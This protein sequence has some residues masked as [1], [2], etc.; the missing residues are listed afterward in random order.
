MNILAVFAVF[1]GAGLGELLRWRLGVRLNP[2]FPTLPLGTL[3]ANLLGGLLAVA[4]LGRHPGLPPG[5]R[6][7]AITGFLGGL[8]PFSTFAA[9]TV[10]RLAR[11]ELGWGLA[12]AGAHVT[13]SLA[14]TATGMTLAHMAMA[15]S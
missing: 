9:E 6:L 12:A 2:H 3:A 15:R 11:G 14:L 4:W 7:F 13:G 5:L 10:N 8:T 1:S